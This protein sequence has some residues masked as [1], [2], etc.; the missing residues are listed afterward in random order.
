MPMVVRFFS[1][2]SAVQANSLGVFEGSTFIVP[3]RAPSFPTAR[4]VKPSPLK[5]II[6]LVASSFG[7][8]LPFL[9]EETLRHVPSK[10]FSSPFSSTLPPASAGPPTNTAM[11]SI[12]N[13]LVMRSLPNQLRA[14]HSRLSLRERVCVP[15]P[16]GHSLRAPNA[17]SRSERRLFLF[18]FRQFDQVPDDDAGVFGAGGEELAVGAEAQGGDGAGMADERVQGFALRPVVDAH[19][20]GRE[21]LADDAGSEAIAVGAEDEGHVHTRLAARR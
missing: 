16:K 8:G 14:E 19:A 15:R 21:R 2:T 10:R 11:A 4:M 17:L 13:C 1:R 6:R 3:L 7:A 9:S 20:V 5:V 12:R 18:L